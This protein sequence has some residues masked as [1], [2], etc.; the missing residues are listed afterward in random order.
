MGGKVTLGPGEAISQS[1]P[2]RAAWGTDMRS[3]GRCEGKS[4]RRGPAFCH[5]QATLPPKGSHWACHLG[6][7]G[8]VCP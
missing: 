8:T 1:T 6:L 4:L 3:D 5:H 7:T 2:A